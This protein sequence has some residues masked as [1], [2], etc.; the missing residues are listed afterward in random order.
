M[1][2]QRPLRI[3]DVPDQ[4]ALSTAAVHTAPAATV[5]TPAVQARHNQLLEGLRRLRTSAAAMK[6]NERILMILGG[7]IAP[8]GL[9]LVILGWLGA[10]RTPYVFEQIPYTISGGLLGVALVFLGAFLYFAHWMTQVVKE[11]RAQSDAVVA[12]IRDLQSEIA[13]AVTTP[14]VA[15]A[16]SA[17]LTRSMP[18][19]VATAALV[20]TANGTM[21]HRPEC[22]VVAGKEGL[23]AV[24][25]EDGLEP[26]KLCDPYSGQ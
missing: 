9:L 8:I 25:A 21:A 6:F 22:V 26:C 19:G 20:A 3:D 17:D 2:P 11:Q 10:S 16:A 12:A 13:R 7:I 15:G 23:R 24:S 1:S 5:T 4:L 18:A 14:V